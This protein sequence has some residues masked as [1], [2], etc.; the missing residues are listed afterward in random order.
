M[1]EVEHGTSRGVAAHTRRRE[2]LCLSCAAYEVDK[3]R[4][5]RVRTG[6]AKA[7]QLSVAAVARILRG[8]DPAEA[9]AGEVGPKT[10]DA[11]LGYRAGEQRG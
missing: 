2:H 1:A 9:L 8:V 10:L 4:A 6:R 3:G 11:L 5:Y 7:I